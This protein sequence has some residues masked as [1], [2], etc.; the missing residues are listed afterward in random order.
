MSRGWIIG[1]I[2]RRGA[3]RPR[4]ASDDWHHRRRRCRG[5]DNGR[6]GRRHWRRF[7]Y[8]SHSLFL[9][10]SRNLRANPR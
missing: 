10:L 7:A 6:A 4:F 9:S 8:Y 5:A 2:A 1:A 3:S